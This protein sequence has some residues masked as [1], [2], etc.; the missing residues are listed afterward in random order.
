MG[1]FFLEIDK[2]EDQQHLKQ[3]LD[4]LVG[5]VKTAVAVIQDTSN[6]IIKAVVLDSPNYTDEKLGQMWDAIRSVNPRRSEVLIPDDSLLRRLRDDFSREQVLIFDGIRYAAEM[7]DIAYWRLFDLLQEMSSLHNTELTT[8][9]IAIAMLD[10]WSVVDSVHRLRDLLNDLPGVPKKTWFDLFLKRTQNVADL[11]DAI[12]HQVGKSRARIQSLVANAEQIWGFL[13]WAEVRDSRYTG[14]WYMMS[15]GAVFRGDKWIYA[16]PALPP[17]PLPFGRI[18]LHAYGKEV[19][20]GK[21]LKAAHDVITALT[22]VLQNGSVRASGNPA[23]G[24]NGGDI[25]YASRIDAQL[26]DGR[27]VVVMPDVGL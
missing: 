10:V 4:M 5:R 3:N 7:A 21:V 25:I 9:Q 22:E 1:R 16:G 2:T 11:R 26:N 14:E 15:P 13:S 23:I 20:L 12:Q 18:R 8:R 19:Y 27:Q 17:A 24:R 6:G